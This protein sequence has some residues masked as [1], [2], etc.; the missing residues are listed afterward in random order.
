MNS[1]EK[2]VWL[3]KRLGEPPFELG[4]SELAEEMGYDRSGIY[5]ILR[6]LVDG[7]LI[8]QSNSTKKYSVGPALYRLGFVY[9][10]RKGIWEIASP[11]LKAISKITEETVSIGIREGDEAIMAHKL[12]SPHVIRLED[13]VGR[14][15]PLNAGAIGK[16]LAAYHDEERVKKILETSI[17]EKKTETTIVDVEELLMEYEIIRKNGYATSNAENRAGSYGIS[18]PIYSKDGV[19]RACLCIA[20]QKYRFTDRKIK[21]WINLVV[22]GANEISHRLGYEGE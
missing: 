6:N 19:V 1:T 4:V 21:S 12:E 2:V 5:K 10:E 7:G 15:Y 17:L 14:K 8:V 3:L 18:A 16:L 11:V 9:S 13:K 20:G 22:D